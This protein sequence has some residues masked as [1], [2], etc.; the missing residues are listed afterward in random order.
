MA[1]TSGY[2]ASQ[3]MAESQSAE[4]LGQRVNEGIGEGFAIGWPLAILVFII[5][6][7]T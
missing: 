5:G 2:H 6:T 4:I 3:A 1:W 7:W